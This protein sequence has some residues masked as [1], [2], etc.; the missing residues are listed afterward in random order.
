MVAGGQK[1]QGYVW[2]GVG[3]GMYF[4]WGRGYGL[5]DRVNTLYI[6]TTEFSWDVP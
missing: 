3:R 2:E 6:N 4:Q 1:I 5:G